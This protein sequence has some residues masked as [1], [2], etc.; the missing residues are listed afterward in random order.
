MAKKIDFM[1]RLVN[2]GINSLYGVQIRKEIN[3]S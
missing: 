1:Q 2:L 3:D